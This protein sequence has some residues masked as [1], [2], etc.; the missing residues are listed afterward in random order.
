[1]KENYFYYLV[2]YTAQ[3][4]KYQLVSGNMHLQCTKKIETFEDITDVRNFIETETNFQN[5]VVLNFIELKPATDKD[6]ASND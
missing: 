4:S 1:M 5:V 3:K 2:A 6:G